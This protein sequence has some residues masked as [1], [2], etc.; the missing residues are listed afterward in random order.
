[1]R[2][3]RSVRIA[4][5]SERIWAVLTDVARWP[6]W[7][8]STTRAER[9]ER[10]A[11]GARSRTR[12]KQPGLRK[13]TW[14]VTE[15]IP[16][17]AFTWEAHSPGVVLS[18]THELRTRAAGLPKSDSHSSRAVSSGEHSPHSRRR[19]RLTTSKWKQRV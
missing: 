9:L 16:P 1:L 12:I 15:F 10:S 3:D 19:S 8:A 17:I 18:A 2:I 14:T 11:L 4:A 7:T 13:M 5:P 6:E